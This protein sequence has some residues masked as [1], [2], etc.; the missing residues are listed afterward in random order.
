MTSPNQLG[1]V[2]IDKHS[3]ILISL[4]AKWELTYKQKKVY[5]VGAA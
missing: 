5:R 2:S 3:F 4:V 1:D